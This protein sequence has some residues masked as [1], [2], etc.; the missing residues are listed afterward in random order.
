R[1]TK[2][3]RR[4]PTA[5]LFAKQISEAALTAAQEIGKLQQI[6]RLEEDTVGQATGIPILDLDRS[7]VAAGHN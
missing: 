6:V 5:T 3:S 2:G 7:S 1:C 4:D